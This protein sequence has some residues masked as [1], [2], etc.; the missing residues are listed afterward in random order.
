MAALKTS[1]IG[2]RFYIDGF[3]ASGDTQQLNKISGGPNPLNVTDITQGGYA[4]LGGELGGEINWA[5]FWDVAANQAHANLSGL[6][7][8]SRIVSYFHQ[9]TAVGADAASMVAK[10]IGYDPNRQADGM[11]TAALAA[12]NS[13]GYPL[14]WGVA[15]T[16]GIRTDTGATNGASV[17]G[18][19][20][21]S[22]GA[23]AYLHVFG[24]TGTSVTVK[25]Q[26]SA[27]NTTFADISGAAFLAATTAGAQR[28]ALT[29]GSTV[30]RYVRAVTTGT[31]TNAQFAVNFVRNVAAVSY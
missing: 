1:G 6:T 23:Q 7:R 16:A 9:P 31:F 20:A 18:L 24:V 27:D 8:S 21:T 30:R 26:D 15:L 4:R 11:L 25:L 14:E 3:D 17:D 12:Q 28:L 29:A 13:D 10:Q 22:F 19:A 5:S 2:D